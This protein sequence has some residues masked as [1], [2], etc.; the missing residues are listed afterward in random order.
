MSDF[1][2]KRRYWLR[3]W[4]ETCG[5]LF[6]DEEIE[7]E[8]LK[9]ARGNYFGDVPG[10]FNRRV[11]YLPTYVSPQ[12]FWNALA[13]PEGYFDEED[14][15]VLGERMRE[16]HL[17]RIATS[18]DTS[19]KNTKRALDALRRAGYVIAR[20][21]PTPDPDTPK[22]NGADL[23]FPAAESWEHIDHTP[24]DVLRERYEGMNDGD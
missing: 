4:E 8:H 5:Y 13:E 9:N 1:P 23:V 20:P 11:K 24:L 15:S 21:R 2:H 14:E 10:W 6:L 19:P 16:K 22:D 7:K 17:V 12:L 18:P 3:A